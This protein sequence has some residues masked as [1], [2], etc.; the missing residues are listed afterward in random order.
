[1][2]L[3]GGAFSHV[4]FSFFCTDIG[5]PLFAGRPIIE[6]SGPGADVLFQNIHGAGDVQPGAVDHQIVTFGIAP[7]TFAVLVMLDPPL[8]VM[9]LDEVQGFLLRQRGA[10]D[11]E[12]QI[13]PDE[14][15]Y[16]VSYTHLTLPTIA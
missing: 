5:P 7:V 14:D 6:L 8:P 10:L 2:P 13:R 1:M 12:I 3:Y 11:P 15:G 16:P 4:A 9:M